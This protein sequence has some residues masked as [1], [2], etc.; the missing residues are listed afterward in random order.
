MNAAAESSGQIERER[1]LI[2]DALTSRLPAGVL[3]REDLAGVVAG[4][5]LG[6][7]RARQL[8]EYLNV[9]PDALSSG[10]SDGPAARIRLLQH[11]AEAFPEHVQPARCV[12]CGRTGRLERRMDDQR[13]CGTCYARASSRPCVRC[14]KQGRPIWKENGGTVC[15]HCANRDHSRWQP[16]SACGK[17]ARV[18]ARAG[19]QPLCQTCAPKPRH[20]CTSC[21]RPE[22]RAAAMTG[23]GP[24]CAACYHRRKVAE[25]SQC[26]QVSPYVRKR[27]DTATY[28]CFSCWQPPLITCVR[29]GE[30]KPIK[31]SRGGT[32]VC[33][34]CRAQ[35]RIKRA[36]V[37]CGQ[38]RPVHSRLLMGSICGPCYTRLRNHPRHCATCQE[39][40]PL[41][42]RDEQG[43]NICGPCAGEQ[44]N[45]LC[46]TCHLFAALYADGNCPTCVAREEVHD[47]L[48][49][50][51]GNV[52]QQLLPL[53]NLL[54]IEG[55]PR[56]VIG[57]LR[58][59]KWA[60]LLGQLATSRQPITHQSLDDLPQTRHLIYLRQV[61]VHVGTL[62]ER[63]EDI[64]GTLP[65]LDRLL[66]QQPASIS[67]IVRPYATWSVLRRAR[68]RRRITDNRSARKHARSRILLATQ[69][70]S[71][72]DANGRTLSTASQSDV[73]AWLAGG[74]TARQRLRDFLLWTHAH[75]LSAKLEIPWP[76]RDQPADFMTQ[77]ARWGLLRR[78]VHDINVPVHLRAA[79]GLVLLFG[80]TPTRIVQIKTTD[81]K[82][83]DGRTYLVLRRCPVILPGGLGELVSRLAEE[84]P[85]HRHPRVG[86]PSQP[87]QWLFPGSAPGSHA[88]ASWIAD[89]LNSELSISVRRARNTALCTLAQ[90]LPAPVLAELLDMHV[91]T[92]VRW[93]KLVKR[94]W[95]S[96]LS[97]RT[98]S[99]DA[100]SPA[101]HE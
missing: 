52:Q 30:A 4:L 16:C 21:Q 98:R 64:E 13:G 63:D 57:W 85:Q 5:G 54:D 66:E 80:L 83:L 70:L 20:T 7:T 96:Y 6:L 8:R 14:G 12:R 32:P 22:Q 37:E 38:S 49:D 56:S 75:G 94:D 69:F 11:L 27:P 92:A 67:T 81:I 10:R 88:R 29:C 55:N 73:E 59:A 9:H 40:R 35:S 46:R 28:L 24:I 60:A 17:T 58:E 53:L 23:A 62:D 41:I 68:R 44:R 34:S 97:E 74:S 71:W 65:W 90:D 82:S 99:Y 43:G 86:T 77:P 25:C 87:N 78:C 26:Q 36:C 51:A 72:L 18:V 19:G 33:D 39:Q 79:G 91:T 95:T 2:V 84:A 48:S 93:T 76:G 3:T 1:G 45:W 31:R 61:L 100:T 15:A 47:L 42:G 101:G 50:H 89:Q